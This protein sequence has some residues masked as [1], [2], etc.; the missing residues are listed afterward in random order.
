[1]NPLAQVSDEAEISHRELFAKLSEK[2]NRND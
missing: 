1:L 2:F